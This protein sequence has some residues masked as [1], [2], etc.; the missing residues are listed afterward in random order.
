[1]ITGTKIKLVITGKNKHAHSCPFTNSCNTVP[2]NAPAEFPISRAS[3]CDLH[4]YSTPWSNIGNLTN[5]GRDGNIRYT[6]RSNVKIP[7][8]ARVP[9][10]LLFPCVLIIRKWIGFFLINHGIFR[11]IG[12]YWTFSKFPANTG[13]I[14]NLRGI[15][16]TFEVFKIF[17]RMASREK[18]FGVT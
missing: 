12:H 8:M 5:I 16:E 10:R 15:F 18:E 1:M 3:Q 17:S 7:R 13:D 9:P 6:I 2:H 4:D 14:N 11:H